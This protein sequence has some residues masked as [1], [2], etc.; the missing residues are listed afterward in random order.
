MDGW[1]DGWSGLRRRPESVILGRFETEGAAMK[2]YKKLIWEGD[3]QVEIEVMVLTPG[4]L[5]KAKQ[6]RET[7]TKTK[8]YFPKTRNPKTEEELA[9]ARM[10]AVVAGQNLRARKQGAGLV[11][12]E[13]WKE[14]L[15]H[16]RWR[17]LM[18]GVEED[19]CMDHVRPLSK[20]GEHSAENLQVLCRGCNSIKGDEEFDLRKGVA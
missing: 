19:L 14:V 13:E 1:M 12:L 7:K 20:G 2:R 10:K 16:C 11:S 8:T 15:A 18:C 17:C 5:K 9:E 3:K 4:W 6:G